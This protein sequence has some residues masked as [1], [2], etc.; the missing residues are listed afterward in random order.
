MRTKL[1]ILQLLDKRAQNWSTLLEKT[2]LTDAGLF[3]HLSYARFKD[4]MNALYAVNAVL[5]A[6]DGIFIGRVPTIL[7]PY[8][9]WAFVVSAITL[10]VSLGVFADVAEQKS[11]YGRHRMGIAKSLSLVSS[12][13]LLLVV[14]V[15]AII[16]LGRNWYECR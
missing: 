16:R 2:G 8:I 14:I 6:A 13:S 1:L 9:S 12:T 10:I 3:K 15:G 7:A 11:W 4:A 5:F